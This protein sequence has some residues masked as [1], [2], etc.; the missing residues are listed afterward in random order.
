VAEDGVEDQRE[1]RV[2]SATF[3]ALAVAST[4]WYDRQ[5]T[6]GRGRLGTNVAQHS[7]P[8]TLPRPIDLPRTRGTEIEISCAD[9]TGVISFAEGSGGGNEPA[10]FQACQRPPIATRSSRKAGHRGALGSGSAT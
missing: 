8:R 9:E 5:I 1:L 3:L 2:V 7:I 4:R 6:G 10:T